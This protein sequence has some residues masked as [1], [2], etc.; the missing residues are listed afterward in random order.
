[1]MDWKHLRPAVWPGSEM[2]KCIPQGDVQPNGIDISIGKLFK[3]TGEVKLISEKKIRKYPEL[4]ELEPL[5]SFWC[6]DPGSYLVE[7]AEE[8]MIPNDAIGYVA[9][10]STL[11]RMGATVYSGIWDKGFQGVGNNRGRIL[12]Q[13]SLP[14]QIHISVAIAQMIFISAVDDKT[15]YQ[16]NYQPTSK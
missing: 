13:T 14:F 4:H 2:Q 3:L 16:G 11:L 12:L 6:L 5:N 10:R 9:P 1:M 15:V 7:V 8:I